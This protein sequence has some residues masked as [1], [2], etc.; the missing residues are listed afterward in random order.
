MLC[1]EH[2]IW[3]QVDSNHGNVCGSDSIS[4]NWDAFMLVNEITM[5]IHKFRLYD[6]WGQLFC[7][8]NRNRRFVWSP[9]CHRHCHS[10]SQIRLDR[11]QWS[12]TSAKQI[13]WP[14]AIRTGTSSLCRFTISN[15]S[16]N[17]L[18]HKIT[19][20]WINFYALRWRHN[21]HGS[22][23]NHQFHDCLLNRLFRRRQRKHQSSASLPFVRGIHGD[24][25]IPRTNGQ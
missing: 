17:L 6:F 15:T 2:C 11:A 5:C 22:I 14:S 9:H 13:L 19:W 7:C 4:S 24:R 3:R 23:S 16:S 10:H 1:Q 12:M 18:N 20:K 8:R 25:W 21:G